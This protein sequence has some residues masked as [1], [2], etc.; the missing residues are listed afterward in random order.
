MPRGISIHIGVNQI[1]PAHYGTDGILRG[2]ENDARAMH[3]IASSQGYETSL[4]LTRDATSAKVLK[5]LY[6]AAE[7]LAPGDILLLTYAGH[8][9]QIPDSD[10]D[11]DDR[12]DETW[13]LYD[14]MMVDDEL[15]RTWAQF[16]PGVRVFMLSDSCH[17]GTVA[18]EY[19]LLNESIQPLVE[20]S[21]GFDAEEF[22]AAG[23]VYRALDEWDA[24]ATFS[25]NLSLYQAVQY[26]GPSAE[27]S[28]VGA[29]VL[30]ISGCQD[31]QTS[32]DLPT[33]GRF[34]S[35]LLQ[36]WDGGRF[37]GSYY[38]LHKKIVNLMPP[39]QVPR[40]YTVGAPSPEFEA[41][42]P[43]SISG[44]RGD[45]VGAGAPAEP[46][47]PAHDDAQLSPAERLARLKAARGAAG[48]AVAVNDAQPS[49]TFEL[50]VERQYIEGLPD[51]KVYEFLR[52]EGRDVLMEAFLSAREVSLPRGANGE[53]SCSADSKGNVKCEGGFSIRF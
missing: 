51:E 45:A 2:C 25:R 3:S 6:S 39:T 43:F 24:E 35:K 23:P 29:S 36:V 32:A 42:R 9:S 30:L 17:S 5:A 33:N 52:G 12:R 15:Y 53:F 49:C 37:R 16:K 7:R 11:E 27:R 22:G 10:G 20:K 44:G 47:T 34:T 18:R 48:R 28:T 41:Q 21:R 50:S 26:S 8:G 14:R 31:N 13:C 19:A 4:L 38:D 40:Y 1:D 46:A